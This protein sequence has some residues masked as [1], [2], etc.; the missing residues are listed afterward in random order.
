MPIILDGNN[1][2]HKM[3][4]S[5]RSRT[6][7]RSQVLEITRRESMSV[8]VV[9]DG[10]PSAGAPAT[11]N[12]GKV[13]VLYAGSKSADD[14]IVSLLPTGSAA[15]QFFV[16]TDDRA[17]ADRVRDCGATVRRVAEWRERPKQK[18]RPTKFESKLSSHDVADWEAFF[19]GGDRDD[20]EC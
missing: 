1:L 10:P 12:L 15:K 6:A 9:F 13:N 3:P 20:D 2:L 19:A 17:L 16:V 14:V 11:E 4:K 18:P 7:V 5:E 8:T